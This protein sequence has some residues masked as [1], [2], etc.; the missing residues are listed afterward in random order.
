MKQKSADRHVASL[1]TRY[2]DSKPVFD[3]TALA[4]KQQIQIS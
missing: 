1:G 4:E 3:L 2:P